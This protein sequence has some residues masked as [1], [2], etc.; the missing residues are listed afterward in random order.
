MA[1]GAGWVLPSGRVFRD[2]GRGEGVRVR[3]L[4]AGRVCGD[5]EA[6]VCDWRDGR[7]VAGGGGELRVGDYADVDFD[8]GGVD[9]YCD[10][11]IAGQNAQHDV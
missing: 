7:G 10:Y 11:F 9:Y 6:E 3:L 2:G 4:A 1:V 8:C 5:A